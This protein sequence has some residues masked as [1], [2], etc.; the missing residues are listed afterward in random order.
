[1]LRIPI[2]TP[3]D[4]M[5]GVA[6]GNISDHEVYA[7]VDRCHS[8]QSQHRGER[9]AP[10]KK[11]DTQTDSKDND[12]QAQSTIKIFLNVQ[13]VVSAHRTGIDPGTGPKA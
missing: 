10:S 9:S 3:V 8:D 5:T 6:D 7:C 2:K 4:R 1:M 11:I 13:V 12:E